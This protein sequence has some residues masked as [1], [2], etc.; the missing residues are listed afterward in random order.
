MPVW[1]SELLE[2]FEQLERLRPEWNR[3]AATDPV[4][5]SQ[6]DWVLTAA[7][8]IDRNAAFRTLVVRG[9][10]GSLGGVAPLMLEGA[11]PVATLVQ[12]GF[13]TYEPPCLVFQDASALRALLEAVGRL[14][15]P[16]LLRGAYADTEQARVFAD[17]PRGGIRPAVGGNWSTAHKRLDIPDLEATIAGK[18]RSLVKR[19]R[20]AAEKMGDV[21][22]T[23]FSPAVGEVDAALDELV[24]VENAG[25]KGRAGTSLHHDTGLQEFFR[26]YARLGAE[27]RAVRFGRVT[28]AGKVAAARMD[29]EW[30]GQRWELKI[31][32][33]EAYS[34]VSPGQLLSYETF[35]DAMARGLSVHNFL[36]GYE[37]SWQDDWGVEVRPVT[38]LRRYPSS[39][40]GLVALGAD[41]IE[42]AVRRYAARAE[43][44]NPAPS[45]PS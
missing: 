30:A 35:K 4:P 11:G 31:G 33:D 14:G 43:K 8:T 26:R 12:I 7:A 24:A 6:A 20:K 44:K 22:V 21:E 1:T 45:P 25:W 41:T 40:R 28:I 42:Y 17:V 18:R 13:R 5:M 19:K 37:P 23:F 38:N 15:L 34:D 36:G 16:L 10:D 29:V 3:L 39:P 9:P 32:F 27:R 2:H